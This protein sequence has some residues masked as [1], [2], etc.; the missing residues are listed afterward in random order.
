MNQQAR[1][2]G[3]NGDDSG[4]GSRVGVYVCHCGV[5]IAATVDVAAVRAAAASLPGVKVARDFKF[6]CSNQGQELIQR[7]IR[8][9]GVDRVVVAACTPLMH[10]TTF[11]GAARGAGLNAYLVQIANIREQCAWVHSDRAA[12]T[13][14][15]SALTRAAAARVIR[16]RP[17]EATRV[18]IEPAAMVVG[19]GIA[20]IQAALEIADAGHDVYLVERDSSIGGKMAKFDK[21]FPTL[22]CAACILTP[23]MVSVGHRPNLHL[24]TLSEVESVTGFVGNFRVRVRHHARYVTDACTSCGECV[25]VCPVSVPS[26]FDELLSERRAI[27]KTFPQ[28]IPSAFVIEK[29]G[30]PPCR[31]AC[32][33]HQDAA[34]Y[35]ALVGEGR[36][37]E[38][39]RL[40]RRENPLPGI[41]GRVCYAACEKACN[42]GSVDQPVAIRD[43]KRFVMD[44]EALHPETAEP[45]PAEADYNERVAIIGSGPAG[46]TAA[47]DLARRGYRVTVFEQHPRAGGMLAVGLPP[48]RCPREVLE[49]DLDYLRRMRI[50]FRTGVA[51]GRDF[52]LADLLGDRPGFGFAAVFLAIG[53]HGGLPLGAPGEHLDGVA[54]GIDYLRKVNLGIGQRTGRKVAVIGGGNTAM[55]AARTARRRGAEVTVLYRRSRTEM[56]AEVGEL[57]DAEAEGVRFEYLIQPVEVLGRDGLVAALRCLRMRLGEPDASGRRRPVAIH[58]SEHER[59]FDQVLV[60]ISQEP[61]WDC[62]AGADS[63]LRQ[64]L[65]T[66]RWGTLDVDAHSLRTGHPRIFAGGD[67]VLGPSTIVQAMGQGRRAAEAIHKAVRGQP[68]EGFTSHMPPRDPR[69]GFEEMPHPYAPR[70]SETPIVPREAMPKR[71]PAERIGD[72][73]AVDLGFSLEQARREALRCLHCGVCVECFECERVCEPGAIRHD[74]IDTVSEVA[75]GQIIVATGYQ[76]FDPSPLA[77][78]GYGR[79]ADVV[80]ALEFERMLSSTGPS[81]GKVL[82]RDGREP[83]AMAIVHCVGSRD[84]R[85]HRYCS[86]VCCMVALKFAHLVRDRTGAEVYQFYLDLRAFGKGYEEFYAHVLDEGVN[87]IRGRVAEVVPARSDGGEGPGHLL[88]RCEDTL[89]GRFREIP[90]DMVVLCSA[91][92]AQGDAAQVARTFGLSRSPDG[93]YLERHPKLDPVGTTTDG[94]YLAG[95]CQGPKDIPDTVAQAQ[96]AAARALSLAARGEAWIDPIRAAVDE[97]LCGGCKTCV[98]LCPYTAISYDEARR[99]AV[100]QEALCKG[101]GTCVAACPTGAISGAG[102]TDGQILAELEGLLADAHA[103]SGEPPPQEAVALE[104]AGAHAGTEQ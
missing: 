77:Q 24:M 91:L 63:E 21:T 6:M 97:S 75:V 9:L 92:E 35:V 67:V 18:A 14:K 19:G 26:P 71:P 49:R 59:E 102:F 68:L 17:L 95:C 3:S 73:E 29:R 94:V 27:H 65:A 37:A 64:R 7:D 13:A 48:Y 93:F 85:H 82:C 46:L 4:D 22:D 72:L 70:Y 104:L 99:V 66:T 31:E 15:A 86:R 60:A 83:R 53:A 25:K 84:E 78:Y 47:H 74:M 28:A 10:E 11:R 43:L 33:V 56:P 40:I 61:L 100:V 36:F 38:A 16:H 80:T 58:G 23:K 12:A 76:S 81:G 79:H 96:A 20:G 34:G 103:T 62:L 89:L 90:V 1:G 69:A 44:W 87:V 57:E 30:H 41:C 54:S 42:R 8:E 32:P 5:N 50:E 45:P 98:G 88:V 52:A 51:L 2:H 101:C 39:A 55:D